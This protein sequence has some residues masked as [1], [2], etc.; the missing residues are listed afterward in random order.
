M[1]VDNILFTAHIG[2][3]TLGYLDPPWIRHWGTLSMCRRG[4]VPLPEG[5]YCKC[6]HLETCGYVLVL[7]SNGCKR[8]I[9]RD[10]HLLHCA[11]E[12][13]LRKTIHLCTLDQTI[14]L[15]PITSTNS[16]TRCGLSRIKIPFVQEILS[17]WGRHS[18]ATRGPCGCVSMATRLQHPCGGTTIHTSLSDP[19]SFIQGHPV[20]VLVS[21]SVYCMYFKSSYCR[22]GKERGY[23]SFY[24]PITCT[25]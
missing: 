17:N 13:P 18:P 3:H 14:L 20:E 9:V 25:V 12:C 5:R 16:E 23:Y 21:F 6:D 7:C 2:V 8:H 22:S 19:S 1:M 4:E 24:Y 10:K 15:L 11:E